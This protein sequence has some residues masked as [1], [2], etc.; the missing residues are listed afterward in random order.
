MNRLHWIR[1]PQLIKT[2]LRHWL[3]IS[4]AV[5]SAALAAA[6]PMAAQSLQ[7]TVH[8][9]N[10]SRVDTRVLYI[11]AHPDDETPS[12]MTYLARGLNADVAILTL[13]RGQGGQNAIG[14]E[15]DGELGIIRTTELLRADSYYGVHQYFTRAVD[16]GFSKS[17]KRTM[18]IWGP[19]I[20]LEDMVRVI[21][22]FRPNVVI[23]GWGGVHWGHG[24]HQASGIYTPIAIADAADPTEFPE[25][26]AEGLKPWKVGLELRPAAFFFGP[27]AHSVP[28]GAVKLPVNDVSPLLGQSYVDIGIEGRAQHR[29]QGTPMQSNSPFFHTPVYLITEHG[30]EAGGGFDAKLLAQPITSLAERFPQFRAALAPQLTSAD[31]LLGEAVKSALNLNRVEAADKLASAAKDIAGLRDKVSQAGGGESAGLLGELAG[32]QDRINTALIDDLALPIDAQADRHE[33]VAGESFTVNVSFL[34]SPAVPFHWSVDQSSLLLPDGWTATFE[35]GNTDG[36]KYLFHVSIPAG[37]APPKAPVDAI[38]PF[39]PPLVRIDVHATVDGYNFGIRQTVENAEAKT[40]DVE[41]FPLELIP[42]VTLTV[43]PTEVMLPVKSSSQP[44]ELLARVR[45]HGTTP[46]K[47]AV[48]LGAPD[49]WNVKPI[50]PL[51]YSVPGSQ[52]IKYVVQPPANIAIGPYPLHPF[53]RLGDET[54]RT[55]VEPLPSLPTRDWSKP[56]NAT[57]HVLD[58][59]MPRDLRVGY[60]AGDNDLVPD[61]LRNIGVQVDMLDEVQLAFGDLSKYDAIVVGIRAYELRPDAMAAN[62]RLLDYVKNGGTLL[63]EYERDFA[64]NRYQPAPFKA[65]MARQAVRVTNP[66]SPVRFLVPDSPLLNT[67]NKITLADFNGWIQERGVYFWSTW[68]P[69]YKALLGLQDPNEPEAT[70]GLVYAHDGKGLYIYTGLD[71][72]RELPAGIPGAYRLFV[73]LISQTPRPQNLQ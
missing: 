40:T 21:R 4:A 60:I 64:W 25:Q 14:P 16:T 15:Q 9:I 28:E 65:M 12:L 50:A 33:L 37:A 56:D 42:A 20:P 13:T 6:A 68:D 41:T 36:K 48:G 51:D 71:F 26:I 2:K 59:N 44:F 24:Q 61:S 5:V 62:A 49:G 23:N 7:E 63:V 35:G 19:V 22:T 3:S 66:D 31:R 43:D 54:F 39:P 27:G 73:N 72:F 30:E 8:A 45:Y 69:R 53:A 57:V 52:L 34:D 32:V 67:P 10:Q 18:D 1:Q 58:L 46:A 17:A 38:L 70:G 55:S 29:S 47:V 11:T